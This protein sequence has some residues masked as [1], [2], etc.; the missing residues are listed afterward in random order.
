MPKKAQK[1]ALNG[2]RLNEL[3]EMLLTERSL[4]LKHSTRDLS[5][6]GGLAHGDMADLTTEISERE[7]ML[8]LAEHDRER[9]RLVDEALEMVANGKY[10]IC[11]ECGGQIPEARL[12]AVPT[13]SLCVSCKTTEE[14]QG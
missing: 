2:K 7:Q 9:L 10:G 8:R 5:G 11:N 6:E 1:E 13:A 12:K 3:K 4:V 14:R